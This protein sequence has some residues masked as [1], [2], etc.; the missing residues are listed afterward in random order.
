MRT[1]LFSPP[2]AS[3][4][5][6]DVASPLNVLL[7]L[8]HPTFRCVPAP[9]GMGSPTQ[10]QVWCTLW[11]V[12]NRHMP[13]HG[14]LLATNQ[15]GQHLCFPQSSN[16]ILPLKFVKR[17]SNMLAR[18]QS[19]YC[20]WEDEIRDF[21]GLSHDGNATVHGSLVTQLCRVHSLR[22]SLYVVFC[23][24][25]GKLPLHTRTLQR[26]VTDRGNKS[27]KC[28]TDIPKIYQRL[29][30]ILLPQKEVHIFARVGQ[31]VLMCL[32]NC[33]MPTLWKM[34]HKRFWKNSRTTKVRK[35]ISTDLY[36]N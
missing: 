9:N 7:I 22:S 6:A 27:N 23:T 15:F 17:W 2:L 28:S 29:Y 21:H 25:C 30:C 11:N 33:H 5:D 19:N 12:A 20:S 35:I 13:S 14:L 1:T 31:L 24:A 4:L 26:N 36:S 18:K 10:P 3:H 8:S 16:S 32:W 34:Q